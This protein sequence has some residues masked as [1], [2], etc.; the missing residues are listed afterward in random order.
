MPGVRVIQPQGRVSLCQCVVDLERPRC[1]FE[2]PR[3][4]F[5]RPVKSVNAR[6]GVIVGYPNVRQ[7]VIRI[8]FDGASERID[9][10]GERLRSELIPEVSSLEVSVVGFG[11]ISTS[12][13]K[14]P[15]LF[16]CKFWNKLRSDL[17]RNG[18]FQL[19]HVAEFFGKTRRPDRRRFIDVKQL[20]RDPYVVADM[21]NY[22]INDKFHAQLPT[23]QKRVDVCAREGKHRTGRPDKKSP[24][25]RKPHCYSVRNAQRE[26]FF[27]RVAR[28][29][30]AYI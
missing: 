24:D 6:P 18:I 25:V 11:N 13:C 4:T 2:D 8:E 9:R 29:R 12:L 30:R 3:I 7:S 23:G 26:V 27:A 5:F 19:Q 20:S 14:T 28:I 22:A 10:F 16:T 15:A 21:A 1:G 17:F